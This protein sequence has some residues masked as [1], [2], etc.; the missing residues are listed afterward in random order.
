MKK[1][2]VILFIIFTTP[3]FVFAQSG[4][5]FQ[6][7]LKR[8]ESYF[9][10]EMIEDIRKAFSNTQRITVWS[11]DVGDFSGDNNNDLAMTYR[12]AGDREQTVYLRLFADIDGYLVNVAELPFKFIEIPLEVGANIKDGTCY[13]SQKLKSANWK[14][15]GYQ[16]INGAVV[17]KEDFSSEK[18]GNLTIDKTIDFVNL[19]TAVK[20]N[21]DKN[22]V[23]Y[24]NKYYNIPSYQRGR[25]IYHGFS[26]KV[27]LN[28]VDFVPIGAYWW[29]G[30][31]DCSAEITSA[32]DDDFLYFQF[33]IAD[34]KVVPKKCDT[35]YSDHISIWFDLLNIGTVSHFRIQNDKVIL[36][37]SMSKALY[38]FVIYPGD[39]IDVHPTVQ[40]YTNDNLTTIQQISASQI[41]A[42][43]N[44]TEK[45][46]VVKVRIP[47][48]IIG[49]DLTTIMG[50]NYEIACTVE[51]H[52]ID[53]EFRPEEKTIL[54]TSKF[55]YKNPSTFGSLIFIP[56]NQ[57]YGVCQNIFRQD[58]YQTLLE[59]GY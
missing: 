7:F 26:N 8:A 41:R 18:I 25:L 51:I 35:C 4:I 46:Y 24:E 44:L 54:T 19:T 9:N 20:I 1:L 23:L 45:G 43:A 55:N 42:V 16:L 50:D 29:D 56:N 32:F 22:K 30:A 59:Y 6:E 27:L 28:N 34:D 36:N 12:I 48:T 39:F 21:N 33:N 52:D 13:V 2:I 10:D 53:N 49:V 40:A 14:I 58:I 57:W 38:N 17:Y 37:D 15:Y 11:W 31:D 47:L 3:F 5:T